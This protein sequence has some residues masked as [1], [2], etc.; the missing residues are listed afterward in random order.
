[1]RKVG[2]EALGRELLGR[3]GTAGRAAD[4]VFGG[5]G[6]T[7]RQ[8][9]VALLAGQRLAEHANPGEA[10]LLVLTGRVRLVAPD[11]SCEAGAG[12]LIAVPQ[13]RHSLEALS[14]AAVL[15]TV[16]KS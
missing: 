2:L 10:T 5:S 11:A 12:D 3:T 8:T 14:D 15:L 9:V 7:L 4:T 13:A 1:M 16:A 6:N